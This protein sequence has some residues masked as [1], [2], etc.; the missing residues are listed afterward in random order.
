MIKLADGEV[1][2]M[3]PGFPAIITD[4]HASVISVEHPVRINR[5]YPPCVVI[6]VHRSGNAYRKCLTTVFTHVYTGEQSVH[7]VFVPGV[8]IYFC[9][10][11]R[12]VTD[13]LVDPPLPCFTPV[14][15]SEY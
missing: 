1:F 8:Y 5:V 7:P 11:E 6:K 15:R 14:S 9:I 10:I 12:P 4:G 3:T 13:I 2:Y